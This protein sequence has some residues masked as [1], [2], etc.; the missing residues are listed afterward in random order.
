MKINFKKISNIFICLLI[1][2]I[3]FFGFKRFNSY[4]NIEYNNDSKVEIQ[5]FLQR[6]GIKLESAKHITNITMVRVIPSGYRYTIYYIDSDNN[7][8]SE[9]I[10]RKSETTFK[11]Y[12]ITNGENLEKKYSNICMGIIYIFV[13]VMIIKI[14]I[15]YRDSKRQKLSER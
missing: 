4:Y 13:I 5:S 6:N 7:K 1:L 15:I 8:Q 3:I 14:I 2:I 10:S 9:S 11:D 12:I